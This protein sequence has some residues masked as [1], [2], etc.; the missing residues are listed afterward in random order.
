MKINRLRGILFPVVTQKD[1]SDRAP[2]G[3]TLVATSQSTL[4][5]SLP[6]VKA[7]IDNLIP[8]ATQIPAMHGVYLQP[9]INLCRFFPAGTRS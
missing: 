7:A 6:K 5:F 3:M 4:Y 8:L 1:L 9:G 2:Q